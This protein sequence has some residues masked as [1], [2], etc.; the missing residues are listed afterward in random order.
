MFAGEG[1]E[2]RSERPHQ[3]FALAE[4]CRPRRRFDHHH[5]V[6]VRVVVQRVGA[7]RAAGRETDQAR[8]LREAVEGQL[9]R[10]EVVVVAGAV[11]VAGAAAAGIG[12]GAG[13][14]AGREVTVAAPGRSA[15]RAGSGVAGGVAVAVDA[16]LGWGS[17]RKSVV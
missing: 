2:Q 9:S 12:A 3:V 6:Q 17:D 10:A 14:G 8:V 16:A 13:D 1:T 7:E 5:E 4:D 11:S 15:V